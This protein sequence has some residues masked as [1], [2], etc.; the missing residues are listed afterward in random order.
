M[1][2][3]LGAHCRGKFPNTGGEMISPVVRWRTWYFP[4]FIRLRILLSGG[5]AWRRYRLMHRSVHVFYVL[6]S[7]WHLCTENGHIR[8]ML[9]HG[10]I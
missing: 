9:R 10:Q 3:M 2:L 1:R 7:K 4:A 6:S 8:C 5:W